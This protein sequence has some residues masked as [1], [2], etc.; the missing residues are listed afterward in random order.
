M[1]TETSSS[2]N[3]NKQKEKKHGRQ[4]R[5]FQSLASSPVSDNKSRHKIFKQNHFKN[6]NFFFLLQHLLQKYTVNHFSK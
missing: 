2:N 5:L 4:P 1:K 6:L 3:N